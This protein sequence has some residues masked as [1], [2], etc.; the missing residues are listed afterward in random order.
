[1]FGVRNFEDLT[2][3]NAYK[4]NLKKLDDLEDK[5]NVICS[6]LP[7]TNS[8]TTVSTVEISSMPTTTIQTNLNLT[9]IEGVT[10]GDRGQGICVLLETSPRSK[11]NTTSSAF[12]ITVTTTRGKTSQFTGGIENFDGTLKMCDCRPSN[13]FS[14]DEDIE[15]VNIAAVGNRDAARHVKGLVVNINPDTKFYKENF[16]HDESSKWVMNP[17]GHWPAEF[18]VGGD[19]CSS[20]NLSCC[21]NNKTCS[22]RTPWKRFETGQDWGPLALAFRSKTYFLK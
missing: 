2:H 17:K 6:T 18:W 22:L 10:C 11:T 16:D 14:V 3:G 20:K 9:E 8:M 4:S 5:I 21:E 12:E 1:M 15:A 7:E 19:D 13:T